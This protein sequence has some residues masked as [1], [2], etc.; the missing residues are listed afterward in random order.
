M[1]RDVFLKIKKYGSETVVGGTGAENHIKKNFG[2]TTEFGNFVVD[3]FEEVCRKRPV[4]FEQK[5]MCAD[6]YGNIL[7]S[8]YVENNL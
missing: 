5:I 8:R 7:V 2:Y 3:R 1:K 4:F 6:K